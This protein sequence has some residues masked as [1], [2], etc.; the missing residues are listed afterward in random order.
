VTIDAILTIATS[1]VDAGDVL[2]RASPVLVGLQPHSFVVIHVILS[3]W[4]FSF[5]LSGLIASGIMWCDPP[6]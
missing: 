6:N 2:T 1:T 4:H 3:P 5:F